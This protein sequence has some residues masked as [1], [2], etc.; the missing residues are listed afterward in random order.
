MSKFILLIFALLFSGSCL[1]KKSSLTKDAGN[2]ENQ[3]AISLADAAMFRFD[4]L[5][6]YN[7]P[8]TYK[9]QYDVALL[10]QA[11]D[12]LGY[13][14]GKYS[15]YYEDYL[16]Y[17]VQEDGNVKTYKISDFNLDNLNGAKGLITLYKRTGDQ[18]YRNALKLFISQVK[19]QPKTPEGGFWHKKIYPEQMWL[20][21]I[22]MCTPFL[23]QYA[24][25]F[26]EPEWFDVITR[27]ITLIYEKTRD[28]KTGLIYHAWDSSHKE[29]WSNPLTGTS[30]NFWGRA[31]GW[32]M[33]ALVDVLDYFP[34][35]HKGRKEII[36]ILNEICSSVDNVKDPDT[37]LW[38]QVLDKGGE[39]DNYLE[40]SSS[41][42]FI[43]VFAKASHKG[44]IPSNYHD[45]AE[46]SFIAA[47]KQFIV[48]GADGYP[49]L[50]NTCGGCGLGGNPYR[51][52]S[53]EYYVTEKRVEND[54][55]GV[56]PFILAAIE[57]KH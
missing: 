21:G 11:I 9:W 37:G 31:T 30:P 26:N 5:I 34:Q 39:P 49:V 47:K 1:Q 4:S 32:Y 7:N 57:L 22:Y 51:D 55:K 29:R 8:K 25:E 14:D 28:E 33:M 40:A 50:I 27:Q 17:F 12:K 54:P 48:T 36:R 53:Y 20:D 16:N 38:Y 42:M 3:F 24:K 13:I 19:E 23:A 10:G 44:Y 6:K 56:A 46:N 35:D 2:T 52:G 45:I 43:Y 15:R 41:L 18:K